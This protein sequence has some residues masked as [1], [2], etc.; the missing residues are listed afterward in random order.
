[1]QDWLKKNRTA[2]I[3]VLLVLTINFI[4]P[5]LFTR[6]VSWLGIGFD[7]TGQIGDTIGGLTAP[8]LNGISIIVLYLAFQAQIKANAQFQA[9]EERKV[10]LDEYYSLLTRLPE[11]SKHFEE[12]SANIGY[13]QP[14]HL[15]EY[16]IENELRHV[17][18]WLIEFEELLI[19]TSKAK[20]EDNRLKIRMAYL[21]EIYLFEHI[22]L[23]LSQFDRHNQIYL[24]GKFKL[25]QFKTVA[26]RLLINM[27]K[28][29]WEHLDPGIVERI[30]KTRK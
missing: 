1:M 30:N 9:M 3:L 19:R 20:A 15:A 22:D 27:H 14:T 26:E 24:Q 4:I 21:F 11:I 16:M 29:S 18:L 10:N 5:W 6:N 28:E 12:L 13:G 2:M 25:W 23:I 7:D 17:T 8:F